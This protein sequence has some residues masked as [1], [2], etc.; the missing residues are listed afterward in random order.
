MVRKAMPAIPAMMYFLDCRTLGVPSVEIDSG[1]TGVTGVT[2]GEGGAC[3]SVVT[4][5]GDAAF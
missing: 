5:V 2:G 1:A 3:T 4:G